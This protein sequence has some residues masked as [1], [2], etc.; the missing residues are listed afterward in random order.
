ME[1][2]M[3]CLPYLRLQVWVI[4]FKEQLL[5]LRFQCPFSKLNPLTKSGFQPAKSGSNERLSDKI[6]C[7]IEK[8]VAGTSGGY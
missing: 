2:K 5:L 4:F 8:I 6:G 3:A 7:A 1:E